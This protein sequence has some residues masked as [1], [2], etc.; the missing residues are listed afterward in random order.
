MGPGAAGAIDIREKS[1]RTLA[2]FAEYALPIV[3]PGSH[4]F[5]SEISRATP[6]VSYLCRTAAV[7]LGQTLYANQASC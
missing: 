6:I 3:L 2:Q 7:A 1:R 4:R 5:S